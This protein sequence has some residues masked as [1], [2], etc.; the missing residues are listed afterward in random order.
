MS[1]ELLSKL[2]EDGEKEESEALAR[3]LLAKGTDPLA[4][5]D[6]LTQTMQRVGDLFAN[7]DLFLPEVMLAGEA[8][9]AVVDIVKPEL[10]ALDR[11]LVKG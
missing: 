10:K 3:E 1:I 11:V 6:S 9:T 8:L 5:L 7:L 2:V 4:I